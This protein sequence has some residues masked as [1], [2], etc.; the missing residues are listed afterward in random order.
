MGVSI[1]FDA[2]AEAGCSGNIK[3]VEDWIIACDTAFVIPR[4]IVEL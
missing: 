3:G 4:T 2:D 1:T